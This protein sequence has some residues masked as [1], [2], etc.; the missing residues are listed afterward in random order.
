VRAAG[1]LAYGLLAAG[2]QLLAIGPW[3][4]DTSVNSLLASRRR[5]IASS[6]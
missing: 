2:Y 6:R 4:F 5:R 3:L 1:I